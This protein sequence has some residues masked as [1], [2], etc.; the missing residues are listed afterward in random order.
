M[1]LHGGGPV[2]DERFCSATLVSPN[3]VLT[4]GNCVSEK[5]L[6][7]VQVVGIGFGDPQTGP[8][9]DVAG[10]SD[11]WSRTE[12]LR[13]YTAPDGQTSWWIDQRYD[14]AVVKLARAAIGIAPMSIT[15]TTVPVGAMAT[16]IAYGR[17]SSTDG[18]EADN[19]F[20]AMLAASEAYPGVR[21]STKLEVG[22]SRSKIEA[23]PPAGSDAA[24]CLQDNGAPLILADGT[25]AGVLSTLSS[26]DFAAFQF[27]GAPLCRPRGGGTFVNL[28]FGEVPTFI[29][30]KIAAGGVQ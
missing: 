28:R 12:S 2:C 23:F 14:V 19:S 1:R 18:N 17:V 6:G 15:T 7:G 3:A 24:I 22:I 29:S 13:S 8:V 21:K 25:L 9:Y 11:E 10:T 27:D 26:E 20:D 5:V 16:T 30:S 4:A